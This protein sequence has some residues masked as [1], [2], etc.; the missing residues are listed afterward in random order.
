VFLC[1]GVC[2]FFNASS[3]VSVCVFQVACVLVSVCSFMRLLLS[4]CVCF[5]LHVCFVCACVCVCVFLYHM[6][7]V[8]HISG[9]FNSNYDMYFKFYC[10]VLYLYIYIAL[11][12]AYCSAHQSEAL[13]L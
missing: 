13:P 9:K 12:T 7:V 4:V 3:F 11:I 2:M 8:Q 6:G 1:M 10:T 5:R